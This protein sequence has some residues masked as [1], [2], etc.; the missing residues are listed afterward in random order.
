MDNIKMKSLKIVTER[1]VIRPFC[2]K[3]TER[4]F[5]LISNPKVHCFE[6]EKLESIELAYKEVLI[7]K[8]KTDCSDLAVCLKDTDEFIGELFGLWEKDTFSICWNFLSEFCGKGYAYEGAK[9]Y[10]TLLFEQMN[11]R[12]I[13]AYVEDYNISSQKLCKKLGMRQEGLFKEFISFVNNEEGIPIY[14]NTMQ[15]AILKKEWENLKSKE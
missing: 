1:L 2:E 5:D 7:K 3:D 6:D 15:F 14:E 8:A 11:A 10:M 12:R 13:Y 9:E 4:Y